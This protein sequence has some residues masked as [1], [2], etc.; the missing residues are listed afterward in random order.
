MRISIKKGLDIA[1]AGT[2]VS[3]VEASAPVRSVALL[4]GDY[5][6]LKA[7]M[8]A[9][10][11]DRVRLGQALF[12]DKRDPKVLF[13][14]PGSGTVAAVNRGARRVLQSV[15]I[16]LDESAEEPSE[17]AAFAGSDPAV[18]ASDE[19]R[20][21]LHTSGLWTAFHARP[22]NKVPQSDST[23]RSIFVTAIDTRPLAADPNLLVAQHRDAFALGLKIIARLTKGP[24]FLCTAPQW[25][26]P[27]GDGEPIRHVEFAGPH[28][29]GLPGT[30]IHHLDP[31]GADRTVWHIGYQDV[32]AIGKLFSEGRIWVERTVALG[33][34]GFERPRLVTTRLGAN[35]DDLVAGEL[36]QTDSAAGSARLISGSVLN[37]HTATGPE[38]FL[39]RYDLQVSAIPDQGQRRLLGW[40]GLFSRRY[41]AAGVFAG[42]NGRAQGLSFTTSQNGRPTA[43]VPA[44]VF[45]RILPLDIL[46][47]PLLRALLVKDTDQA[48]ALGCLELDAEDL[49]LCSF[50]CPGKNDYGA[51]LELNLDQI[52][53]EG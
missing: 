1:V 39:G 8:L 5:A 13:T 43:L 11:G 32:I 19:I 20:S 23:P 10:V 22:Y 6:G 24:V 31:V 34:N 30:H 48:Q 47:I 7:R 45:E 46:P 27:V 12:A 53:R 18:I 52:E 40:L 42:R 36:R 26:G 17:F 4:G 16:E 41:S 33:G 14:A 51:V 29:A 44:D 2:P 9:R 38:A 50:V 37:G 21:A 3:T 28:P 49:A 25:N 15:V 35:M